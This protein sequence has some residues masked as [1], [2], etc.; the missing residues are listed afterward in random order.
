MWFRCVNFALMGLI[1]AVAPLQAAESSK[2]DAEPKGEEAAPDRSPR[3]PTFELEGDLAG[4]IDPA[5]YAALA[6]TGTD[7][8]RA[9]EPMEWLDGSPTEALQLIGP[10]PD[11]STVVDRL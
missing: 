5:L 1:L 9:V 8:V 6:S 10:L 2:P 4:R 11:G 7:W 3:V